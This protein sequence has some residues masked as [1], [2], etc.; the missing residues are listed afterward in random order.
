[1]FSLLNPVI[2]V[3]A[4][5]LCF[6]ILKCGYHPENFAKT[7]CGLFCVYIS[8]L[9]EKL[10]TQIFICVFITFSHVYLSMK[11]LKYQNKKYSLQKFTVSLYRCF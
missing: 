9:L 5:G 4:C 11:H 10:D 8:K 6:P 7:S 1:M 3:I 2:I